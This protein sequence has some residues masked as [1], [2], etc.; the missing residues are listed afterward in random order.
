MFNR[1]LKKKNFEKHVATFTDYG[2]IK[3]LDFKNPDSIVY[4]IRF[5]F[6][7]DYYRLHISGDLGELTASNY[8]NMCYEKFEDFVRDPGYFET[9]I[10]CHSRPIYTFDPEKA[11]TDLREKL[12]GLLMPNGY[13]TYEESEEEREEKID[14]I[15]DDFD[16]EKG[17]GSKAVEILEEIDPDTYLWCDEIGKEETGIIELYMLAFELAQEQLKGADK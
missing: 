10:D 4:R 3:I 12:N 5:V 11:R 13:Q 2:N 9:K 15:L 7:E 1:E 6:E 14:E 8:C 17:L 16:Y